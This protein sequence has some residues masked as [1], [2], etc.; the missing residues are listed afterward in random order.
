[1]SRS[2][3][4]AALAVIVPLGL[5]VGPAAAELVTDGG[6]VNAPTVNSDDNLNYSEWV[7]G[8]TSP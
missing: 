2:F 3:L 7:G 1:M 4:T 5:M 6:F 8:K